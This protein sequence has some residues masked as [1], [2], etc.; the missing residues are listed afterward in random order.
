MVPFIVMNLAIGAGYGYA[1]DVNYH[2]VFGTAALLLFALGLAACVLYGWEYR[3]L[4]P[5]AP[6]AR[7]TPIVYDRRR[8]DPQT[9]ETMD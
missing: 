8:L 4:A 2:Y 7:E 9:L 5:Y 3:P 6:P 1:A